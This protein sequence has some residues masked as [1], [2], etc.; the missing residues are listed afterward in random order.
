M[1]SCFVEFIKRVE[2]K[3]LHTRLVEQFIS[4]L[5]RVYFI[6]SIIQEHEC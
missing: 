3:K 4:C 6:N 2:E 5:E 1:C